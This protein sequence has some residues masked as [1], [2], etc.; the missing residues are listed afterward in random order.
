MHAYLAV[1]YGDDRLRSAESP[2][3]LRLSRLSSTMQQHDIP[4]PPHRNSLHW[5]KGIQAAFGTAYQT[6]DGFFVCR[7]WECVRCA[8]IVENS[9]GLCVNLIVSPHFWLHI[10][11][12][13]RK[14]G[15]ELFHQRVAKESVREWEEWGKQKEGRL[16]KKR[17]GGRRWWSRKE[18]SGHNVDTSSRFAKT[19]EWV[20]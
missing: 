14:Q 1:S 9:E 4:P 17:R 3:I 6:S 13:G 8:D 19:C 16:G 5:G 20:I 2:V 11:V 12:V 15:S 10:G 18:A 7:E